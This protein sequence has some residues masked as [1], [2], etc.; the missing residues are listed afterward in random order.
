MGRTL[1]SWLIFISGVVVG[2]LLVTFAV[3]VQNHR[4]RSAQRRT[5]GAL[6]ELGNLLEENVSEIRGADPQENLPVSELRVADLSGLTV[7]DGW[8]RPLRATVYGGHY[9]VWSAGS[10]G[11]SD[12]MRPHGG[13]RGS[14][15]DIGWCDGGFVTWPDWISP[16]RT[17]EDAFEGFWEHPS[18]VDWQRKQSEEYNL[19]ESTND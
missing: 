16:G 12:V 6:W 17:G 18:S 5:M 10:D 4:E 2:V 11:K 8:G 7:L 15:A 13:V 9:C 14:E 1:R 3:N 19:T